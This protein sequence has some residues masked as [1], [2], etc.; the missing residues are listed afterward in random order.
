MVHIASGCDRIFVAYTAV[1][2]LSIIPSK[3]FVNKNGF[4]YFINPWSV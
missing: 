3:F 4:T 2:L 1:Y